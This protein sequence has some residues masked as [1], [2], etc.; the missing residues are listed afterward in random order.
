MSR[1]SKFCPPPTSARAHGKRRCIVIAG[2]HRSGT[3]LL[4]GLM[5]RAGV[6][7]PKNV[8]SGD[9]N[10]EKGY[11]EPIKV[12]VV[13]A[14]ILAALGS[15]WDDWRPLSRRMM[16]S[17]A[18]AHLKMR[19]ASAIA[20]EFGDAD[21]FIVKDPRIC[22][23]VPFWLDCFRD[24][25]VA[26]SVVIPYRAPDE[27]AASHHSRD[28]FPLIKGAL[29]WLRHVLD[30]EFYSRD[31]PRVFVPMDGILDDWPHEMKRINHALGLRLTQ[32]GGA[33]DPEGFITP[34]LKHFNGGEGTDIEWIDTSFKILQRLRAG[35][36][37][38]VDLA[39]LDV[40][41][42]HFDVACDIFSEYTA[43]SE[44]SYEELRDFRLRCKLRRVRG[45]IERAS[46]DAN[47]LGLNG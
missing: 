23:L 40:V 42:R 24:V 44:M 14:D 34:T 22:R 1:G 31:L 16:Q 8:N 17:Q 35:A 4:A 9:V 25:G 2:M 43:A 5:I 19:A 46:E 37:N 47:N 20:D 27:V 36:A 38:D 28:G 15:S 3:S 7:G 32:R 11:F 41:R 26:P 12:T 21:L 33:N 45:C 30:A 18:M 10:N 13:N 39:E 6:C 29:L